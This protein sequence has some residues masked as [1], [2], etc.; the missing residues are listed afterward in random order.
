MVLGDHPISIKHRLARFPPHL[1]L[2][3]LIKMRNYFSILLA[4]VSALCTLNAMVIQA[5]ANCPEIVYSIERAINVLLEAACKNP[6]GIIIGRVRSMERFT[7]NATA[8]LVSDPSVEWNVSVDLQRTTHCQVIYPTSLIIAV[9]E[10]NAAEFKDKAYID[11][12]TVKG[13]LIPVFENYIA[14]RATNLGIGA[15][16]HFKDKC[17]DLSKLVNLVDDN[18]KKMFSMLH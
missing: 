10:G 2:V 4:V 16:Q 5:P 7:V 14:L 15:T 3:T 1:A 13:I 9:V 6:D 8:Q 11:A 18:I 17:D 12:S